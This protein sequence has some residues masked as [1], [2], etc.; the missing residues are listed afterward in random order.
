MLMATEICQRKMGKA[1]TWHV[2]QM[3]VSTA[4]LSNGRIYHISNLIS[5]IFFSTEG[6]LADDGDRYLNS[7]RYVTSFFIIS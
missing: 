7:L 5:L 6:T 3:S 4:N 1:S 2:V